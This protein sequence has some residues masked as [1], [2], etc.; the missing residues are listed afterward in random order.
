[1]LDVLRDV[2]EALPP[3][4]ERPHYRFGLPNAMALIHTLQF[5]RIEYLKADA[6]FVPPPFP[7][8]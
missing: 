1:V 8:R 6:T 3:S 7:T 4:A 5:C 2:E